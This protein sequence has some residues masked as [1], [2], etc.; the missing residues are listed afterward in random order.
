ML[1]GSDNAV[2]NFGMRGATFQKIAAKVINTLEASHYKKQKNPNKITVL[3]VGCGSGNYYK[4]LL[5]SSLINNILYTGIDISEKNIKNSRQCFPAADFRVGNILAL[6]FP[7][8]AF[9]LVVVSH[10]F[11]HLHPRALRHAIQESIRVAKSTVLFN[12]FREKDIPR[13][14]IELVEKYHWNFLS[15]RELIKDIGSR[16]NISIIDKYR[17]IGLEGIQFIDRRGSLQSFSSWAI[18]KT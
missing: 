1:Y 17:R 9:D 14:I 3:D 11:E 12:F 13:H 16:Y 5:E 2:S 6:D 4:G 7:E 8:R 18:K 15:R 10:V